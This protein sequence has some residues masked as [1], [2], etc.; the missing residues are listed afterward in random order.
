M[1][2]QTPIRFNYLWKQDGAITCIDSSKNVV[3]VVDDS[4]SVQ[5]SQAEC[6]S[7]GGDWDDTRTAMLMCHTTDSSGVTF[8]NTV[9]GCTVGD[10]ADTDLTGYTLGSNN[11]DGAITAGDATTVT[12]NS[13]ANFLQLVQSQSILQEL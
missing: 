6:E 12:V 10:R 11:L 4:S 9:A 7:A 2:L 3:G 13:T 8:P 5:N 1:I